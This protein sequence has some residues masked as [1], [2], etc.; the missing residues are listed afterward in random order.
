MIVRLYDRD[1]AKKI[2]QWCIDTIY[3]HDYEYRTDAFKGHT[4]TI[5][6]PED[7]MAFKLKFG[8]DFFMMD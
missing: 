2:H 3:M 4:F 7:S 1:L 5:D 6:K 8:T